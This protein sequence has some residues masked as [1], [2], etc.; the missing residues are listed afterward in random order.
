MIITS[1]QLTDTQGDL[2]KVSVGPI[3]HD[4]NNRHDNKHLHDR[5][6]EDLQGDN[7]WVRYSPSGICLCI[8]LPWTKMD[9]TEL[10]RIQDNSC[11]IL[12]KYIKLKFTIITAGFII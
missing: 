4:A 12:C 9:D 11:S 1:I 5:H 2:G 3:S 6:G 7:G 8:L 10:P